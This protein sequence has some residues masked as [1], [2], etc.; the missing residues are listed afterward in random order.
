MRARLA[1]GVRSGVTAG[2]TALLA[3]GAVGCGQ[4]LYPD[5][6]DPVLLDVNA[7][8][9]N[10]NLGGQEKRERLEELG[11]DALT[12]NALLRDTRTANQFGGTLRT[13]YD[14]VSAGRLTQLSA[15]E[16][17]IFADAAREV[18]GGPSFN[19]TDEQAQA[20][21]VVL[22]A[23]NLSTSAQVEAFLDDPVNEV[24]STVPANALKELFVDFDPD[25]VL[26]Q[27]P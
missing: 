16:I 26:D 19:L 13:A 20:I 11:L 9:N 25:E 27:L 15:D 3:L 4:R 6:A 22:G 7:I 8:V 24:P 12:I 5:A 2:L 21:V 18:S 1:Y 14:K 10:A 17:Q 23:N